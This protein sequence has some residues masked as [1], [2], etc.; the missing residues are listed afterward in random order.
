[1]MVTKSKDLSGKVVRWAFPFMKEATVVARFNVSPSV[2]HKNIQ[3]FAQNKQ[4]QVVSK[5]ID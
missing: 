4:E 1:M 3:N 2:L 5:K